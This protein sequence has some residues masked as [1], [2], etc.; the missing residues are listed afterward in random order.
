[1]SMYKTF[2]LRWLK[3]FLVLACLLFV[4]LPYQSVAQNKKQE[5]YF[6]QFLKEFSQNDSIQKAHTLFPLEY[7]IW[8]PRSEKGSPEI[9]YIEISE[10]MPLTLSPSEEIIK[11]PE[12]YGDYEQSF[13]VNKKKAIIKIR[14]VNNGIHTN[15]LF[16]LKNKKWQLWCIEDYST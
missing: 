11:G 9:R 7:K 12:G 10:W 6:Q 3:K 2:L 13:E 15:I 5:A 4:C 14:G 1:M 16:I 8:K